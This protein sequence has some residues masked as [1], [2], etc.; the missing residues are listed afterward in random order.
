MSN[1]EEQMRRERAMQLQSQRHARRHATPRFGPAVDG[2]LWSRTRPGVEADESS[3]PP[4]LSILEFSLQPG[5]DVRDDIQSPRKLWDTTLHY[6]SAIP[7]CRAIEWGPELE[8]PPVALICLIHWDS[9]VAWQ[10]FQ[11]SLGFS[12]I[13]GLLSST[14]SNR[15]AKLTTSSVPRLGDIQDEAVVVDVVSV[16][17]SAE[18]ASLPER[19]AAFEESWNKL[20]ASTVNE[21]G[22]LRHSYTVWLENN[23]STF[24]KPTPAEAAAATELAT[25]V[26]FVAWDGVHYGSHRVEDLCDNLRASLLDSCGIRPNISKKTVELIGQIQPGHHDPLRQPAALPTSL[27]SVQ[28]MDIPR[29]CSADLVNLRESA[30]QALDRSIS[31]ARARTRLFPAPQG[32]FISQGELYDGNM[33][34]IPRWRFS[35]GPPHGYHFV[36]T[37]WI[38]LKAR[39]PRSQSPRIY[40]QLN[41]KLS[42]LPGFVKAF[43]GCDEEDSARIAVLTVWEG[44]H[45]RAAS[46]HGYR[47]ILDEFARSSVHLAAP[48]MSQAFPMTRNSV[49]LQLDAV[50][51]IE[52]TCFYVQPGALERQL[53][54]DSYAAFVRMTVPSLVAGVPT[55]CRGMDSGGWQPDDAAES[56]DFQLFTGVLTWANPA[57]RLEWYEELF[58]LSC[59]SY[60]LFGHKLD[61]LKMLS[62]EIVARFLKLQR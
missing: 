50:E 6:I 46:L 32:S 60:E 20:V 47:L 42:I 54:E 31:D 13:I 17:F 7:G 15:C 4:I 44:L 27:E 59:E 10:R 55:A 2:V 49:G 30:R 45:E 33:P 11:H 29:Q 3:P 14:V 62:G 61:A 8:N 58:R 26:A 24:A 52:L 36:D 56:F 37:V 21:H 16:T 48:L 19:R 43:W 1:Q 35:R 9:A 57:A 22:I 5:I 23:A 25:L 41:S 38:Q 39:T 28:E 12:P 34:V 18:D 40:N 51:Y 53:F